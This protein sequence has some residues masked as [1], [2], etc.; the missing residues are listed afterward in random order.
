MKLYEEALQAIEA[1]KKEIEDVKQ[2]F[3]ALQ[4]DEDGLDEDPSSES[5]PLTMSSHETTRVNAPDD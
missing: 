4:G 5:V 1:T 3:E 2:A